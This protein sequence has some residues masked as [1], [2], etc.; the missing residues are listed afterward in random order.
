MTRDEKNQFIDVLAEKLSNASVVYLADTSALT[1]ENTNKLR[2]SAFKQGITIEVVKNTLL[3]KAM[4]KVEGSDYSEMFDSLAGPTSLIT[5]EVGNAPAKLIQEFRKKHDKPIL[6]AAYI[7]S[8]VYIGDDQVS[9][10]AALKSKEE[11]VGEIIG[12]LQSPIK[13]VVSSLQ[14]GGNTISGLVK[15]LGERES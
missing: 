13:N 7:D 4:E 1:V 6:K 5:S 9:M 3:K 8:A 14:S 15:A 10:L 11:L 12:L 2:R